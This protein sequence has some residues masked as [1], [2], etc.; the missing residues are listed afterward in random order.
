MS[1]TPFHVNLTAKLFPF[2]F[3]ELSQTVL[4]GNGVSGE[5][6]RVLIG[7]FDG[8]EP[9]QQ[10]GICQAYYMQN[11][12]PIAR[13]Y[14]SVHFQKK[15]LDHGLGAQVKIDNAFV[16]RD[17]A[18]N[19]ALFGPTGSENLVY[20]ANTADWLD[21]GGY[22]PGN[23]YVQVS[24]LKGKSYIFMPEIGLFVYNFETK[25]LELQQTPAL[26]IS[27]IK[28]MI[29]CGS[30]LVACDGDTIFWSAYLN[31]L[32]FAPSQATGA[33]ST[34]VLDL[35]GGVVALVPLATGFVIY[36]TNN[37][38]YATPTNNVNVPWVFKAIDGAT[39]LSNH[40]HISH[41]T[42]SGRH[43]VWTP[44]GIQEVT[45]RGAEL[46]FPELSDGLIRG[47]TASIGV[48]DRPELSIVS[49][50][51]IKLNAVATK[52]ICIS[53][54][55]EVERVQNFPY[56]TCFVYDIALN[57]WGRI[58]IPHID[59]LEFVAP[60]L[61]RGQTYGELAVQYPLYEDMSALYYSD[62]GGTIEAKSSIP[63]ENFAFI[64]QDGT[65]YTVCFANSANAE[66]NDDFDAGV[67]SPRLFFGKFK[68]GRNSAVT[69]EQINVNHLHENCYLIAHN[70]D[71]NGHY[72]TSK[73]ITTLRARTLGQYFGRLTGDCVSL[74]VQGRFTISDLTLYFS[75]AGRK[76]KPRQ[77]GD[78]F[79]VQNDGVNIINDGVQVI[80]GP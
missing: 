65:L 19:V 73:D 76:N 3:N 28:W 57:R 30:Y 24:H 27:A 64:Q 29:A 17:N 26:N 74:E 6:N 53:T 72:I 38:V 42:V 46:A 20:D 67:G 75:P 49:P 47:M 12:L 43:I 25:L 51:D 8:Q 80:N 62:I 77:G 37:A 40:N 1:Q 34:K 44:F 52:Y 36:T 54:R 35:R 9:V 61:L 18:N 31:P 58:D 68:V 63:N 2:N 33:G 4:T 39:G 32:D 14:S 23:G 59:V 66:D 22:Y 45:A 7:G 78:E 11:V 71:I 70:H 79:Y 41:D 13:G 56:T 60:E 55:T 48:S 10:Y 16:V 15:L 50:L 5:Q 69:L 21:V